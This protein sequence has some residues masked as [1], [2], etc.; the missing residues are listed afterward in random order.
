MIKQRRKEVLNV[1]PLNVSRTTYP[2]AL[3]LNSA[4]DYLKPFL[5]LYYLA[6][7]LMF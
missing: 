4:H 6:P 7:S 3:S 2:T 5:F 1:Q